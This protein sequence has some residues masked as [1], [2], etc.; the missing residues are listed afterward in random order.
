MAW[1]RAEMD[2]QDKSLVFIF[3]CVFCWQYETG[4]C[5]LKNFS[6]QCISLKYVRSTFSGGRSSY[7][8]V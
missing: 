7:I 3:W 4:I 2:D 8:V 6:V 5:G 1:L